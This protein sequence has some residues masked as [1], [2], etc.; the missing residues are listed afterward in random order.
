M[1]DITD[2]VYMPVNIY[3]TVFGRQRCNRLITGHLDTRRLFNR[4]RFIA[5]IID[6]APSMQCQQIGRLTGIQIDHRPY[7]TCIAYLF[8]ILVNDGKVTVGK[9]T[10]DILHPCLNRELLVLIRHLIQFDSQTGKYPCV[11]VLV[12][13]SN[14]K[15]TVAGMKTCTIQQMVSQH[16]HCQ[17]SVK[18]H[19]KW[20][21]HKLIGP[22][23]I[24]FTHHSCCCLLCLYFA[25]CPSR[26]SFTRSKQLVVMATRP[27]RTNCRTHFK[28]R[29][30][31]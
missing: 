25:S 30:S 14:T 17:A 8:A 6:D 9:Q 27:E 29:S 20:L 31:S 3:I 22:Y 1:L 15:S 2:T 19:M 11:I 4:T 7:G 23:F 24:F 26:N 16:S 28:A 13:R 21:C 12:Q 10:I 18:V 5:H